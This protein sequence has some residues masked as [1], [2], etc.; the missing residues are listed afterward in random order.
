MYTIFTVGIFKLIIK[1]YTPAI[2]TTL[3]TFQPLLLALNG[4]LV[5]FQFLLSEVA[6]RVGRCRRRMLIIK[7]HW[8]GNRKPQNLTGRK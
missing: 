6:E 8:L 1:M 3:L 7:L 5:L 4:F 2:Q